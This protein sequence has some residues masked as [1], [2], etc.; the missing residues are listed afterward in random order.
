MSFYLDTNFIVSIHF[1]DVHTA[2]SFDW[3]AARASRLVVSDWTAAEYYAL[4]LRRVRTG[5]LSAMAASAAFAEFDAFAGGRAAR[6]PMALVAGPRAAEMARDPELKLSA[7]DALHMAISA[8]GG[9][10][11]VT[12]D[13]RLAEAA[14]A[15]GF[16]VETP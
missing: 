8:E 13:K 14:R 15:R 6:A 10:C 16:A 11:L 1:P 3:L 4:V 2:R 12:F 9:H 7:A 5:T